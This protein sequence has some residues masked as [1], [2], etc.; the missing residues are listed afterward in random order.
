MRCQKFLKFTTGRNWSRG[1]S[2]I[3]DTNSCSRHFFHHLC[4]FLQRCNYH[5]ALKILLISQILCPEDN[6]TVKNRATLADLHAGD[7][8]LQK[9]CQLLYSLTNYVMP[10]KQRNT[11]ATLFHVQKQCIWKP[12][13]CKAS[14]LCSFS[15]QL[16]PLWLY[17]HKT[18][19]PLFI[20]L[21]LIQI[22][23]FCDQVI[24]CRTGHQYFMMLN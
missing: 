12:Q 9:Q 2:E 7:W 24:F 8:R 18:F 11:I 17:C 19:F 16:Y 20:I 4:S 6:F 15:F 10:P 1:L 5:K 23:F 13:Y 22:I 3:S 21:C 14:F